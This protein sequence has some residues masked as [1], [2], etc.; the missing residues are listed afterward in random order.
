MDGGSS[1]GAAGNSAMAAD[2]DAGPPID[3]N[4]VT[5]LN[6]EEWHSYGHDL[7]QTRSNSAETKIGVN[8]VGTLKLKWS[9]SKAAV[10]STPVAFSGMLYFGDWQG[11]VVALDAMTGQESWRVLAP[12]QT[13]VE[14]TGSAS[15]SD[16]AVYIGG[17]NAMLYRLDRKTGALAWSVQVDPG[18]TSHIYSSPAVIDNLAIVG[19]ASYQN[20]N[21]SATGAGNEPF[22][23]VIVARDINSGAEAWKFKTTTDTGVGVV[24]SAAV[25]P[26]RKLMF[27]GT[28]Q[29]YTGDSPY[30]D[31]LIALNYET[32]KLAWSMQFTKGDIYALSKLDGPDRDLLTA[33]SLF[34]VGEVDV[35]GAADKAGN[36][37]VL[38]RAGKLLWATKLTPGGHHGGVMGSPAYS[39]GMIYVCS[40]DYTTDMTLGAG[41]DGPAKSTLLALKARDGS[42]AWTVPIAGACYGAISYANGVVYLPTVDGYLRAYDASN[43][44]SLWNQSLGGST[45]GGVSMSDGML[46]VSWGWDWVVSSVNGGVQAY[47]LP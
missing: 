28:G 26:V 23:G 39:N 46:F 16:A 2:E 10:T 41:Q 45:A 35:V 3:V 11:N 44:T 27:V 12:M 29:N 43:G 6:S 17:D 38:D 37:Y 19:V 21:P 42:Q 36:Y 31:S 18:G 32:G 25:D 40:G 14:I 15:V 22:R 4:Q 30:A 13:L 34:T 5:G 33:P 1:P 9:W 47:G 7:F 20:I 24:S 8:N